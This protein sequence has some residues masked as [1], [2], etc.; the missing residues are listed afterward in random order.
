LLVSKNYGSIAAPLCQEKKENQIYFKVSFSRYREW[1]AREFGANVK[2]KTGQC[3]SL[4]K[5]F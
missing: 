3:G 1:G 2:N 4:K 5:A